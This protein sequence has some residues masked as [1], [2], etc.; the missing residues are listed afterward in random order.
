MKTV[1]PQVRLDLRAQYYPN[2]NIFLFDLCDFEEA[3]DEL[4]TGRGA[5]PAALQLRQSYIA[6]LTKRKLPVPKRY[7]VKPQG[8]WAWI[9]SY[10]AA[11]THFGATGVPHESA[12]TIHL[13]S[14]YLS[15]I[16]RLIANLF[17]ARRG[18]V[19]CDACKVTHG[20]NTLKVE[21]WG[22]EKLVGVDGDDPLGG[23][24][25]RTFI[26]PSGHV[27]LNILDW[28]R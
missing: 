9:K 20:A 3:L 23:A 15:L 22:G 26:C 10:I 2:L 27:V 6:E 1:P 11:R 7:Y 19:I 18:N 5:W 25:G 21:I 4:C 24:G 12:D 16:E 17:D 28:I 8:C 14:E 13:T